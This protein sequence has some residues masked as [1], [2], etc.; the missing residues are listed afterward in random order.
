MDTNNGS[1]GITSSATININHLESGA[2]WEYNLTGDESGWVSGSGSSL[3]V[4]EDGSYTLQVRQTDQAGNVSETESLSF[5]LDTVAP[6]GPALS[7]AIDT[8]NSSDKITSNGTINVSGLESDAVW[9]Y[10]LN[11]S[12]W[13]DGSGSSF[14]VKGD[15]QYNLQVRQSD[16]AGNVS[17]TGSLSFTLDTTKPS[18]VSIALESGAALTSSSFITNDRTILIS[19]LESGATW[20]YRGTGASN[21]TV[22]SGSSLEISGDDG[23]KYV[24]IR[25]TDKAGNV[26]DF[27]DDITFTLDTTAPEGPSPSLSLDTNDDSDGITSSATININYLESDATWEYKLNGASD[28][29]AGTGTSIKVEQDGSYELEVRQTDVA[30]NVSDIETFSFTL[31]TAAPSAASMSL[32]SDTGNSS[33]FLTSNGTINVAGLESDAVWEYSLNG[34]TW[35]DGSGSSFSVKGDA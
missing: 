1:D 33:D 26:Q 22:G 19:G 14:S 24:Q 18:S 31:D 25:Q 8:N 28:W 32:A 20:E 34:S 27:W 2:T 23:E 21:W 15:A 5:T 30:G 17:T 13:A 12:T 10:S 4:D 29:S 11:G 16:T 7:L 35:T 6:E 9:E 3:R